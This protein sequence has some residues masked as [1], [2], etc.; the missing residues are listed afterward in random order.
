MASSKDIF[1]A[2]IFGADLFACGVFRGQTW[3]VASCTIIKDVTMPA[4]TIS[5]D[6]TMAANTI[7]T[8]VGIGCG[9][10]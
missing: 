1:E 3:T 2:K 5:T 8:D 10:Q 9:N 7:S 6:I 4:N